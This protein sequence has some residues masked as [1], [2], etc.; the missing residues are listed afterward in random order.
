MIKFVSFVTGWRTPG[1]R[2]SLIA[3]LGLLA[4]LATGSSLR[5]DATFTCLTADYNGT[6]AFYSSGYFLQL[7]SS[8]ASLNGRF[9][10]AGTF[11]SNGLGFATIQSTAS[12]NGLV[13]PFNTT[14]TY[15][16]NADCTLSFSLTLPP[17]LNLPA[18]L[19]AVLSQNNGQMS[20]MI[21]DPP[22]ATIIS[23]HVKQYV[24]F[25]KQTD[26]NGAY[27]IDLEGASPAVG[28]NPAGPF[29]RAG[30]LIADGA[31]NFTASSLANYS[32]T[33]VREIFS[34]TYNL[35]GNCTLSLNYSY[36]TGGS[37]ALNISLTGAL[38][39]AGYD[40]MMV[41]TTPGW[42]VSGTLKAVQQ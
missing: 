36:G 7:P 2:G 24:Q 11:T 34:G 25:C 23:T 30:R 32:G 42:T 41:T 28:S 14:A 26:L 8:A 6:Y 39:G 10:Q 21:T 3:S 19:Q 38:A 22:G 1:R 17:P 29:R 9:V 13:Q 18:T 35:D 4:L 40:A 16:M 31:G 33:L 12:Y 20:A 15:S 37:A 5:A 27:V